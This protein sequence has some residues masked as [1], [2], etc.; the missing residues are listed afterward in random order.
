MGGDSHTPHRNNPEAKLSDAALAYFD[1]LIG[2][3]EAIRNRACDDTEAKTLADELSTAYKSG[4]AP[5]T[6]GDLC[7]FDKLLLRLKTS[8]EISELIPGFESR[9]IEVA[10]PS[11]YVD[12]LIKSPFEKIEHTEPKIRA[13][14][15]GLL[16]EFYRFLMVASSRE[17][18]RD[19]ASRRLTYW[20]SAFLLVFLF[21]GGFNARRHPPP[22]TIP[23]MAAVTM[24]Q[25]KDGSTPADSTSKQGEE[26]K[27]TFWTHL[28]GTYI[29]VIFAG[30]L[31]GFVSAQRRIQ[32]VPKR[33]T[34]LDLIAM[35]NEGPMHSTAPIT[36]AVFALLLFAMFTGGLL[37]GT[38]FPTIRT[39]VEQSPFLRFWTY[40][41][42]SGPWSGIDWAKLFVWSFA[43]GFAERLVPDALSRL[44]A[45]RSAQHVRNKAQ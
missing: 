43:A 16:S 40:F 42:F 27:P 12:Y 28:S 33:S 35:E 3:Y 30:A 31:G 20:I 19:R 44:T 24:S 4:K 34:L 10:R 21:A 26:F 41:V 23:T 25:A 13:R 9:Y 6:W 32:S 7:A 36:G 8:D 45:T 18:L 11:G 5:L 1:L 37:S 14:S 29:A 2:E 38:A 17:R 39:P 22:P 15:D